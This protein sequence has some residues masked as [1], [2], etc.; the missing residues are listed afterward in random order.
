MTSY[1][2]LPITSLLFFLVAFNLNRHITF[3]VLE[4]S[5]QDAALNFKSE[6]LTFFSV[7]LKRLI[8]DVMWIQTLMD[9]DTEHYKKK[10]LNSWLYLRFS[11][12]ASL[13]PKFYENYYYGSQ[14]LMVVKDDIPGSETLLTKGLREFPSDVG[15]NWQM[16][17]LWGIERRDP[18]KALPYFDVIK[19]NPKRPR[20][21]DSLYTKFAA[22]ISG[23]Q[24]AYEFALEAWRKLPE[25]DVVKVRLE[26]QIYTLKA[27]EDLKCL[28][29]GQGNCNRA[30]FFGKPYIKKEGQWTAPLELLNL[31]LRN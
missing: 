14:Y 22:N 27:I 29:Q 1:L 28:N 17:Y 2:L 15:L 20:F 5:K 31:K 3:P 7:G 8:S 12:I 4:V 21:F 19:S 24:E 13:D 26:K 10:D 6:T 9:S 18:S 30:D 16:G 25:G 23:N 11:T